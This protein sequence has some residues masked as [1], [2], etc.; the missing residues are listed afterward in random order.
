MSF[1]LAQKFA[2]FK[3]PDEVID[4]FKK[5]IPLV[6]SLNFTKMM[7]FANEVKLT[8]DDIDYYMDRKPRRDEDESYENMKLRTKLANA[9]YK[10]R[11]YL[12]DYSVFEKQ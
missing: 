11:A 6:G 12:Y 10:Y 4:A 5:G 1:E 3:L 9:L 8:N 2:D 7:L